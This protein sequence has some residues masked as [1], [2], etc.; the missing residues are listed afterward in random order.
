LLPRSELGRKVLGKAR[1]RSLEEFRE[2]VPL[3]TYGDYLPF[4]IEKREDVL[5]EKPY[6]WMRTSGRSGYYKVKWLPFTRRQFAGCG[7]GT[8]AGFVQG[9]ANRKGEMNIKE[10]DIVLH[11]LAPPPYPTGAL[12][13]PSIEQEFPVRFIPPLAEGARMSFQERAATGLRMAMREGIQLFIGLPTVLLRVAEMISGETD[14]PRPKR[15][16]SAMLHPA[17]MWRMLGGVIKSKVAGRPLYPR[18]LWQPKAIV[19]GATDSQTY[20]ASI[21]KYWGRRPMDFYAATETGTI[22]CTNWVPDSMSFLPDQN[23]LEFIPE[24]EVTKSQA[25]PLY[26]PRTLLLDEVTPGIYELVITNFYGGV[27][28][29][30][31]MGDLLRI[32]STRN[33]KLGIDHPQMLFH[34]RADDIIDVGGFAKVNEKTILLALADA[35]VP[36]QDWVVAREIDESKPRLHL[37]LETKGNQQHKSA[38]LAEAIHISLGKVDQ[39]YKDMEDMLRIKGLKVTLLQRGT[40]MKYTAEKEA[41]GADLAHYKPARMKP[42]K[43]QLDKLLSMSTKS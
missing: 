24:A 1:P 28:M 19:L 39:D 11:T 3:T 15:Q 18:D 27:L 14:E 10:G 20:A 41:Q 22:A 26:H 34:A 4:L 16:V 5:P 42:T 33:D 31:R 35:K 29:R 43:E 2:T 17:V 36:V 37:Y 21:E 38:D 23:F 9:A 7:R 30:Y 32:V 13:G 8:V 40:F 12:V 6:I 25:D